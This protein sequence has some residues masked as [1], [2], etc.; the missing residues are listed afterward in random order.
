MAC[1][2][3]HLF[4][5]NFFIF[6]GLN[7]NML[8]T[9]LLLLAKQLKLLKK[10]VQNSQK[11]F[12]FKLKYMFNLNLFILSKF[13]LNLRTLSLWVF[14]VDIIFYFFL[15]SFIFLLL[16]VVFMYEFILYF[17]NYIFLNNKWLWPNYWRNFIIAVVIYFISFFRS[18]F[19]LL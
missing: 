12:F 11:I 5:S 19:L 4:V 16:I 18:S 9:D 17:F 10:Q 2:N 15:S 7:K 8:F 14:L 1:K 13:K 3:L 6:W